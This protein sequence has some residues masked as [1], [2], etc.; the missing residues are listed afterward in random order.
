MV[1]VLKWTANMIA[2]SAMARLTDVARTWNRR[3]L[4]LTRDE[5]EAIMANL[6]EGIL[7]DRSSRYSC[8]RIQKRVR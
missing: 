1:R 3:D 5:K 8:R 6:V 4:R 2:L 7:D